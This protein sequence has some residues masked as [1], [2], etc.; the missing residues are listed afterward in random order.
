M[1]PLKLLIVNG[2]LPTF[3][4]RAG[5]EYLHTTR[6]S[7]LADKVGL[8]SL[9]HTHEQHEQKSGLA[10]AGVAL[11][12]WEHPHL[13][14]SIAGEATQPTW[15]HRVGKAVYTFA[16]TYL[17][18]PWDTFLQDLQFSNISGPLLHAFCDGSWQA[19]VVVQSQ[20]AHWLDY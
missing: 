5:H 7:Q 2:D 9:V 3:P 17:L 20:C 10:D 12:L 19:L 14:K 18:R 1:E 4:G 13:G 8:V 15:L 11:Y 16:R 6:L